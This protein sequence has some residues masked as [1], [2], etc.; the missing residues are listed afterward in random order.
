MTVRIDVGDFPRLFEIFRDFSRLSY[1]MEKMKYFTKKMKY[2]MENMKDF[3]EKMKYC[4]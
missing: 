3:M 1:F 4:G 2:F